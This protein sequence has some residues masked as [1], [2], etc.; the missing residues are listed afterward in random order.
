MAIIPNAN[1]PVAYRRSSTPGAIPSSLEIAELAIN[2]PD[3]KLFTSNGT[4]V[5]QVGAGANIQTFDTS[6]TWIRP[7]SGPYAFIWIMCWGGGGSGA[8][9]AT[10]AG[11]GG[12]GSYNQRLIPFSDTSANVTVTVGAGGVGRSTS[13]AGE[14]GSTSSF[15]SFLD[16]PGGCGGGISTGVANGGAGGGFGTTSGAGS[17]APNPAGNF[18]SDEA[19]TSNNVLSGM[20]G[21]GTQAKDA[22]H[23]ILGF[24][25]GGGSCNSGGTSYA[26]GNG[27]DG[28]APGGG[29]GRPTGTIQAGGTRQAC[30]YFV[31]FWA[32]NTGSVGGQGGNNST[33]AANGVGPG[34]GG[35]G[36]PTG[37]VPSGN[38]A[39][40][41]V[42]VITW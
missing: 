40:G 29:G 37:N 9:H 7:V 23:G 22:K 39:P 31:N 5:R 30:S 38:G 36:C 13:Q 42:V 26:A 18:Y 34:A 11:G 1:T 16:A 17:Y 6:G 15:G 28:G 24:G 21:N 2:M 20:G 8:C 14:N 25:G 35:G 3:G 10:S 32:N 12:G 41:R 4:S 33:D 27:F 19:F